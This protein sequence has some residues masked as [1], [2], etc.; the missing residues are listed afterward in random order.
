MS[1]ET[2]ALPRIDYTTQEAKYREFWIAQSLHDGIEPE[3]SGTEFDR[4]LMDFRENKKND[5][6]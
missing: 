4:I 2:S 6:T 1:K 5:T 3:E